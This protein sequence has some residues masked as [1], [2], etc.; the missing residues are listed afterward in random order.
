MDLAAFAAIR[1]PVLL[2]VAGQQIQV[3]VCSA[4]TWI[5]SLATPTPFYELLPLQ[6]AR[7][8]N[9]LTYD[10]DSVLDLE[11]LNEA[12]RVALT[13]QSGLPWYVAVRLMSALVSDHP[14]ISGELA[15]RNIDL[16]T[17]PLDL[18][19][20]AVL[21]LVARGYDKKEREKTQRDLWAP[22]PGQV[23]GWSADD[24]SAAFLAA[25][26]A[27]DATSSPPA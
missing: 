10:R 8:L 16:I 7:R 5:A 13:D 20:G 23:S 4:G 1:Q 22:P 18:V 25:L 3:P 2:S 24:E 14:S 15:L 12:W 19:L 6:T 26:S 9:A 11:M 27:R 17:A 21:A